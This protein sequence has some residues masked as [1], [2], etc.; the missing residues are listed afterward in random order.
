MADNGIACNNDVPMMAVANRAARSEQTAGLEL[1]RLI[2]TRPLFGQLEVYKKKDST[3]GASFD[4]A[5]SIDRYGVAWGVRKRFLEP[6]TYDG[7]AYVD[8]QG[9]IVFR[10]LGGQA[11]MEPACHFAIEASDG[12]VGVPPWVSRGVSLTSGAWVGFHWRFGK[13]RGEGKTRREATRV[14]PLDGAH[15]SVIGR[16]IAEGRLIFPC[17]AD[18]LQMFFKSL[19][20]LDGASR[21]DLGILD[22]ALIK[23]GTDSSVPTEFQMLARVER[24]K[25]SARLAPENDS[26][27]PQESN[28]A[29]GTPGVAS[30]PTHAA[31]AS[32]KPTAPGDVVQVKL[33][34]D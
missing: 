5:N 7:W 22:A 1:G 28:D 20:A 16:L 8:S 10:F 18:V 23:M 30:K 34:L 4:V 3:I 17:H 6:G 25:L 29:T 12:R 15:V 9:T 32:V 14:F 13:D 27:V 31:D 2:V 21:Q 24:T 26:A 33:Q 11:K 19:P